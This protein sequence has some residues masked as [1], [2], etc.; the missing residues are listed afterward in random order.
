ME[1][2]VAGERDL[3][4]DTLV[5]LLVLGSAIHRSDSDRVLSQ[6]VLSDN[7]EFNMSRRLSDRIVQALEAVVFV[8]LILFDLGLV[9]Q[10]TLRAVDTAEFASIVDRVT[11][12]VSKSFKKTVGLEGLQQHGNLNILNRLDIKVLQVK[13]LD[14]FFV[15]YRNFLYLIIFGTLSCENDS[16]VAILGGE[17]A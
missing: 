7:G 11:I 10:L 12:S 13:F 1:V 17:L 15:G 9:T 5:I 4:H 16:T 6:L 2:F 3:L 14:L 8:G